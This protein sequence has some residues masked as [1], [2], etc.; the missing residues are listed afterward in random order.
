[1]RDKQRSTIVDVAHTA[2]VSVSTVSRVINGKPDVADHTRKLVLAAMQDRGFAVNPVARSLVGGQT[3]LI[4][5]LARTLNSTFT[6]GIVQGAMEVGEE[7]GY[8]LLLLPRELDSAGPS[9]ALIRGLA[10]GLLVVSPGLGA[11]P[12]PEV[13][14]K[15]V[16]FIEQRCGAGERGVTI[17]TSNREGTAEMTRYLIDLGHRRIAFITGPAYL[18]SSK[19][20]L[21]GYR[22]TLDTNGLAFDSQYVF[23]GGFDVRSGLRAGHR[24][25]SLSPPPTAIMASNDREAFGVLQAVEER[26]LRVPE[27]VSVVGFDNVPFATEVRPPLTT[28]HQPV[29]EMGR[30]AMSVLVQWIEGK[31]PVQQHIEL[32]TRLIIRGSATSPSERRS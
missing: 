27:D 29:Y 15:P 6:S 16:V 11:N 10:D 1:M 32:P 19:E 30:K 13:F 12:D 9:T 28:I 8:G 21:N 23:D 4:G 26:H 22:T 25:L 5:V 17:T 7:A 31:E 20:R 2:G 3:R 14:G 24:F 18:E